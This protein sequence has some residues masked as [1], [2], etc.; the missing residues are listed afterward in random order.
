MGS[1][2]E[3]RKGKVSKSIDQSVDGFDDLR[4]VQRLVVK[5]TQISNQ[6][7]QSDF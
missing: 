4:S 6:S 2:W 7:I 5:P 1:K 3:K